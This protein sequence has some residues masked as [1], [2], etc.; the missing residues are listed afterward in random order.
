MSVSPSSLT[1]SVLLGTRPANFQLSLIDA[2]LS[3]GGGGS[4]QHH[5]AYL[6][7]TG[8]NA[9]EL[10]Q[11]LWTPSSRGQGAVQQGH[12]TCCLVHSCVCKPGGMEGGMCGWVDGWGHAFE[13]TR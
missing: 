10:E 4:K 9:G 2:L 11:A 8:G 13:L 7:L 1:D 3:Q 5:G 12:G 6:A